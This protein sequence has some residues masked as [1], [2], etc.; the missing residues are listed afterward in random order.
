MVLHHRLRTNRAGVTTDASMTRLE[1]QSNSPGWFITTPQQKPNPVLLVSDWEPR[2]RTPSAVGNHCPETSECTSA[3][4]LPSTKAATSAGWPNNSS[5][6]C[7]S[8]SQVLI[9]QGSGGGCVISPESLGQPWVPGVRHLSEVSIYRCDCS[10]GI[11]STTMTQ[12]A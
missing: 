10:A 5:T 1:I 12:G 3:L 4:G 8:A 9:R 6:S 11:T 7:A 2:H